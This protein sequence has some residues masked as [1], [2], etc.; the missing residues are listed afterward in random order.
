MWDE[1]NYKEALRIAIELNDDELKKQAY[2][3]LGN[4]FC[5]RKDNIT[6]IFYYHQAG[7]SARVYQKKSF[8]ERDIR[9]GLILNSE[10][11]QEL[12][13]TYFPELV[14]GLESVHEQKSSVHEQKKNLVKPINAAQ[15]GLVLNIIRF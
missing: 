14:R 2:V 7:E 5:A 13:R 12:I 6:G 10:E 9:N 8:I 3:G 15:K 11:N 1:R 4:F